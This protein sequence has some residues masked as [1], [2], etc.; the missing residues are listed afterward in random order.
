MQ[1]KLKKK[2]THN[3]VSIRHAPF[4]KQID[5]RVSSL[6]FLS[7]AHGTLPFNNLSFASTFVTCCLKLLDESWTQ[8][9]SSYL[10]FIKR[11]HQKLFT[12]TRKRKEDN[13]K[14]Y[15]TFTPDPLQTGQVWTW[16]ELFAPVP[17]QCVINIHEGQLSIRQEN[18]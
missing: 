4:N 6:H 2:K 9:L 16:S 14:T 7:T 11:K 15:P 12:R 17:L 1:S 3:G 10:I 13:M 18:N 8:L 5:F